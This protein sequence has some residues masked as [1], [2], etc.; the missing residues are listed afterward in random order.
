[1]HRLGSNWS[2]MATIGLLAPASIQAGSPP[3]TSRNATSPPGRTDGCVFKENSGSGVAEASMER[4]FLVPK[5]LAHS[6]LSLCF[7]PMCRYSWQK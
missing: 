3:S 1:M 7:R 4:R 5:R 6:Q 2:V